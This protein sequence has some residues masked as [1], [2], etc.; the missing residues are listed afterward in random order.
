MRQINNKHELVQLTRVNETP[1][2]S[3]QEATNRWQRFG[4]KSQVNQ[5]L[6]DE[7]Y[8]L[9]AYSEIRPDMAGIGTHIEHVKPKS[10]FPEQ[11]FDHNN[12]VTSALNSNDLLTRR[13]NWLEEIDSL[14]EE[15]IDKD[16]SL[17]DL[18]AIHLVPVNNK[19]YPFF[20]STRARF[21]QF[22]EAVLT[23]HAPA[24]L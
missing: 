6:L 23:Q 4:H 15:H 24:L 18:A 20:T 19:I 12:L 10:Q 9:C 21:G 2:Q 22:A 7:Q 17:P 11:T 14:I 3:W 1:P 8:G 16:M 13:R 5:Y